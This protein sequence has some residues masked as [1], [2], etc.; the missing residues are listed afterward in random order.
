M[1]ERFLAD[2]WMAEHDEELVKRYAGKWV[3]VTSKGIAASAN[4]FK[5]LVKQKTVQVNKM[6]I[7]RVPTLEQLDSIWIL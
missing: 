1:N 5:E 6:I 7:T 2:E 3:A 4:S